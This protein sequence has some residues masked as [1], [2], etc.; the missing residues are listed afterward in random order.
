MVIPL[1]AMVAFSVDIG[2]LVTVETELQN[3]AD[4][5][6]LAGTQQL[7]GPYV[8]WSLPTL[9]GAQR[10]TIRNNAI[11]A[12][13]T[14]A[15][16]YASYNQ[17][18]NVTLTVLDGDIQVG[19]TDAQGNYNANPSTS[20]FPNTVA[21]TL[22]RDSSANTPVKLFFAPVLGTS[23]VPMTAYA[24]AAA[25]EGDVTTLKAIPNTDAHILPVALDVNIWNQFL[26]DGKTQ[27]DGTVHLNATNGLPELQVYPDKWT[28]GNNPGSFGLIDVGPPQNNVPAFRTW[29]D[30]GETPNDI[31]YLLN[32]NL[33]PVSPTNG[34][35]WK[36]G[37]GLKSTLESNFQSEMW[38][39]NLI[40]LF[41]PVKAYD[42]N[43]PNNY[44]AQTGNGQNATYDVIGFVGVTISTASGS[45]SNMVISIQPMANVDPTGVISVTRPMGTG[46]SGSGTLGGVSGSSVTAFQT[47]FTSPKLVK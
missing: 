10:N 11:I 5:A 38:N 19:Y 13:R 25:M 26:K 30:T 31:S 40:P 22:R 24:R 12:A 14:A 35:Q 17:A 33:L 37:P 44:Q 9:T 47:T 27:W 45:G 28:T 16:N 2:W 43:N 1:L 42:P 4:A 3:S 36:C 18:G 41:Q 6:A 21:I 39:Q 29:I 7:M 34:K 32:N 20:T 46:T 23:T 8:Q 15:K